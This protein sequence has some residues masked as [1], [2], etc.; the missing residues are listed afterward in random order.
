[1]RGV[2][3]AWMVPKTK[4][5]YRRGM[6]SMVTAS[7][8]GL[9]IRTVRQEL[10]LIH[11]SVGALGKSAPSL[12]GLVDT[13][14]RGRIAPGIANVSQDSCSLIV[15]EHPTECRHRRCRW[16]AGGTHVARQRRRR[17]LHSVGCSTTIRATMLTT[18]A[19]PE[20]IWHLP[21]VSTRPETRRLLPS[22]PAWSTLTAGAALPQEL[23]M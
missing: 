13:D 10:A 22:A 23:R 20:T 19:I 7:I 1:M 6:P 18:F 12:P 16:R 11:N 14:G 8:G 5:L 2:K 17:C 15:V 4:W 21:S 3:T 9:F